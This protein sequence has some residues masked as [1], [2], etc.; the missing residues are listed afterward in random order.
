LLEIKRKKI[1]FDTDPNTEIRYNTDKKKPISDP[2]KKFKR[3][4]GENT[5]KLD[6]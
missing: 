2:K 1:F 5:K 4:K 6:L 3:T